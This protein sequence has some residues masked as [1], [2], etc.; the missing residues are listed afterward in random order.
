MVY[1]ATNGLPTSDAMCIMS[2]KDG[3]IWIGG[4]SG[5]IKYDGS[6]FDRLDT[7]EGLTSARV[8]FEDSVGRIWVGTNDNGVVVISDE[9]RQH[10]TYRDGLT[11]SSIRAFAEDQDGHVFIGTTEGLCFVDDD[12]KIHVC[13]NEELETE[14]I[15]RLDT[16]ASGKKIYGHTSSGIIFAIEY[17]VVTEIYESSKDISL[18]GKITGNTTHSDYYVTVH[19][20]SNEN[21]ITLSKITS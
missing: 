9:K 13:R 2:A 5:V 6:V 17:C 10:L 14:R 19:G 16:D 20:K 15:L 21:W 4:Y 11:S 18:T 12:M 7:A 8:I 1:D 3:H